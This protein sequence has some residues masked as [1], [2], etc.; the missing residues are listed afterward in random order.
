MQI[1]AP[2]PR[3]AF[4]PF[5]A[6]FPIGGLRRTV[7][8]VARDAS[9]ASIGDEWQ[10]CRIVRAGLRRD[11]RGVGRSERSRLPAGNGPIA[12]ERSGRSDSPGLDAAIGTAAGHHGSARSIRIC[13]AAAMIRIRRRGVYVSDHPPVHCPVRRQ[14]RRLTRPAA[15]GV[16]L[17]SVDRRDPPFARAGGAGCVQAP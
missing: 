11:N 7:G 8:H 14:A 16:A 2:N 9:A 1:Q 4:A 12:A 6:A 5:L 13:F 10:P 17:R 15:G 3:R